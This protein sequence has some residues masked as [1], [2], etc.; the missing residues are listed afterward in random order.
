M[1][2]FR[3]KLSTVLILTALAA[4]GMA[5]GLPYERHGMIGTHHM[6]PFTNFWWEFNPLGLLPTLALLAFLTWKA[7]ARRREKGRERSAESPATA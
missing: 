2:R 1:R 5:T 7:V 3:F 6:Q 4:W